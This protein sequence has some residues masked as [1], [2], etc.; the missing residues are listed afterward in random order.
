MCDS[1]H[2]TVIWGRFESFA[3]SRMLHLVERQSETGTTED[4]GV[5]DTIREPMH[6]PG[7]RYQ[8]RHLTPL[9]QHLI[10]LLV[11]ASGQDSRILDVDSKSRSERRVTAG[12]VETEERT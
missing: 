10:S 6:F 3:V 11:R 1:R 4:A 5:E 9:R 12:H 7:T 8:T 2:Q